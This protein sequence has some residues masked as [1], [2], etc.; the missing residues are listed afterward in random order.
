MNQG[1]HTVDL[2]QW[3]MGPVESVSAH[4][5]SLAHTGIE[6]E[7]TGGAALRFANGALGMLAC[8]TSMW[9]GHFRTLTVGGTDGTVAMS[10]DGFLH[11]QFRVESPEDEA[12]R[13]DLLRLPTAVGASSPS[14]GFSVEGHRDN[15]ADFLAAVEAGRPPA[16]DGHEARKAV[17][18][19]LA[20]YESARQGG[21]PV[22]LG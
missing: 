1:I 19:V 2:L 15:L 21:A 7:D 9:P 14:A 6:V 8:T 10:D 17:Q 18:I 3:L 4:T 22:R 16:V 13:R 11:W 20:I 12:L 5:A